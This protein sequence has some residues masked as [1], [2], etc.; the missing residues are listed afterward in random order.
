M[1]SMDV[2]VHRIP[3][4][5]TAAPG[6]RRSTA[7]GRAR[8]PRRARKDWPRV[9]SIQPPGVAALAG[10]Q[11]LP[12]AACRA[13]TAAA[14]RR[15]RRAVA[16]GTSCWR[17]SRAHDGVAICLGEQRRPE[18]GRIVARL[19]FRS[20]STTRQRAASS[21]ATT[22]LPCRP[23]DDDVSVD[24]GLLSHCV[25]GTSGKPSAQHDHSSVT[26]SCSAGKMISSSSQSSDPQARWDGPAAESSTSPPHQMYPWPSNSFLNQPF[27]T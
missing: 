4:E 21:Q 16:A 24:A 13:G 2:D 7:R 22:H 15:T 17:A 10:R 20:S 9:P 12:P 18:T 25:R 23:D 14:R 3:V 1:Q 26:V 27:S 5:Q 11:K 6:R 8:S 19:A